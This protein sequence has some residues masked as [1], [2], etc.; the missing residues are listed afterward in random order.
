MQDVIKKNKKE[1]IVVLIFLFFAFGFN[2]YR[3]QSDGVQYYVFL[4]RMLHIP[5]PESNPASLEAS[6]FFQAG[7]AFFNAPFYL[8]AYAVETLFNI[9]FNFNGITLRQIS[10]N[11]AS[12]F[13][14]ILS[15]LL[16][17][18]I[19]KN[20][21]YKYIILPVICVLFSTAAFAAAV[22]IP[23]FTHAV[24]IFITT[25]F[26]FL[27]LK[28]EEEKHAH[29]A[30][31][32]GVIYVIAILIRYINF[33]LIVPVIAYYLWVKKYAN[34]KYLFIGFIITVWAIPL[35]L[36]I[37]NGSVSPFYQ[38][39]FSKTCIATQTFNIMLYLF[40][41]VK[42]LVH[43]LH[44]LFVWSPVTI[45]SAIGLLH[46]PRGKERP[47]YLFLG[48]WFIFLVMYSFISDEW[49]GGWSFSS[50]YFVNLFSI[51]TIGL[52]ALFEKHGRKM[53]F[54]AVG[55][56]FYSV[57]LFWNWYQ[58]IIHGEFGTPYDMVR[59][60]IEGR[61]DTSLNK[62]VNMKTFLSRL[63]EM[64]RYKYIFRMVR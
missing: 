62:E 49:H 12:N 41:C 43:P 29:K 2:I 57:F 9:D 10:I 44:G 48:I 34:L 3:V 21:K 5:N 37:F 17:V 47:G 45:L 24:D 13:Y 51:Y 16:T 8:V 59:A 40:R 31:W 15:I 19:L 6:F 23:S 28:C 56:T 61:S 39:D 14:M 50:R 38:K 46:L 30:L 35:L 25:L 11:L 7:C 32:L 54:F 52:A 27:F 33:A 60:W 63:W 4:E 58:C 22:V 64:C 26:I 1:I 42:Y 36:Y 55:L 20:L 53:A 18:K